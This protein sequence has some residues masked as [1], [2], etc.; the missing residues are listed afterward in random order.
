MKIA[1]AVDVVMS[2]PLHRLYDRR[3]RA[4]T[5]YGIKREGAGNVPAVENRTAARKRVHQTR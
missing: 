1:Q 4:A 5:R 3:I 2:G